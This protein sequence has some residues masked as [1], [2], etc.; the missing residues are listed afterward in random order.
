MYKFRSMKVNAQMVK[1]DGSTYNAKDD[2]RVTR[3]GKLR[4]TSIDE[5]PK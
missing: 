1:S 4:E 3:I 2:S 5:T